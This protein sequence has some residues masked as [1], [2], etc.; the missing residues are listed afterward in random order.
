MIF[1]VA[2]PV[3]VVVEVVASR[4]HSTFEGNG[5][6]LYEPST[7]ILSEQRTVAKSLRARCSLGAPENIKR[8]TPKMIRVYIESPSGKLRMFRWKSLTSS[9]RGFN[10]EGVRSYSARISPRDISCCIESQPRS[11]RSVSI[12]NERDLYGG[13]IMSCLSRIPFL[14]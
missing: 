3:V 2:L 1:V 11:D 5:S 9:D 8:Q 14:L 6:V 7:T 12:H 4:Y 10:L 13:G